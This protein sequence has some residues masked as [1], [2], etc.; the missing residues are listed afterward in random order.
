MVEELFVYGT[1]GLGRPNKHVLKAISGKWGDYP[2][3][4]WRISL[5]SSEDLTSANTFWL[6]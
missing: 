2:G 5:F 3:R 6:G 1:L 4:G